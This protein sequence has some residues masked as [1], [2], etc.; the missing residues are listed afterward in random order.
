M[1][2]DTEERFLHKKTYFKAYGIAGEN[3]S[4]LCIQ[5]VKNA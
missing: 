4:I 1:L 3:I 5:S 2:E